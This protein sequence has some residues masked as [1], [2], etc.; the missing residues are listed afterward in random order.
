MYF[1]I[2]GV[3]GFM[4]LP[5][6]CIRNSG[7]SPSP[8]KK[9]IEFWALAYCA[10]QQ[11]YAVPFPDVPLKTLK[12]SLRGAETDKERIEIMTKIE[13]LLQVSDDIAVSS[14]WRFTDMTNITIIV[15]L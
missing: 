4:F 3:K 5:V 9:P 1:L 15:S 10:L 7:P 8:W 6:V 11:E 13:D 12:N 14:T 2:L